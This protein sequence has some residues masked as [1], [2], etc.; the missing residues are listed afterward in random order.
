MSQSVSNLMILFFSDLN[1]RF[2]SRTTKYHD[3]F[4]HDTAPGK[5]PTQVHT[6]TSAPGA[7][8]HTQFASIL[9]PGTSLHTPALC[10]GIPVCTQESLYTRQ[11]QRGVQHEEAKRRA[12]CTLVWMMGKRGQLPACV[13]CTC[14]DCHQLVPPVPPVSLNAPGAY[15]SIHSISALVT[16]A[17]LGLCSCSRAGCQG[18]ELHPEL[19]TCAAMMMTHYMLPEH[20]AMRAHILLL[21]TPASEA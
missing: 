15:I 4:I 6:H 17:H 3:D 8:L 16:Q 7:S 21:R 9:Q 12:A 13:P 19:H 20:A 10:K 18:G 11:K 14:V 1:S 5:L 2:L